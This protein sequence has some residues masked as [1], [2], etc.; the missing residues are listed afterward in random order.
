MSPFHKPKNNKSKFIHLL[1]RHP[2]PLNQQNGQN[3]I[4]TCSFE[5]WIHQTT[6]RRIC[7]NPFWM[8]STH[9]HIVRCAH[10]FRAYF[11]RNFAFDPCLRFYS[12][13][14]FH[15]LTWNE[16]ENKQK[17]IIF[18][19]YE[20]R[21]RRYTNPK[22]WRLQIHSFTLKASHS[23]E[24][25]ELE[26]SELESPERPDRNPDLFIRPFI[27]PGS[28]SLN[29]FTPIL[30]VVS[31][32]AYRALCSSISRLFFRKIC[33]RYCSSLWLW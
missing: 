17:K 16:I 10:R 15:I 23:L 12:D 2:I 20:L 33:I 4:R 21:C 5:H 6:N 1:W 7:L 11:S 8:R 28:K 30:N 29:W 32:R 27:S 3:A 14:F 9:G 22:K 31:P 19:R 18:K 13:S 24:S 26:S 25:P